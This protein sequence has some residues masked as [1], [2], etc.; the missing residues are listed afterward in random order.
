MEVVAEE[1]GVGAIA[2]CGCGAEG[3]VDTVEGGHAA[4]SEAEGA[5]DGECDVD[6][7]YPL[8]GYGDARVYLVV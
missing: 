4:D 8:G 3:V 2:A 6:A 1:F 7:S 5:E